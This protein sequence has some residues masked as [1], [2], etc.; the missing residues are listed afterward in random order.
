MNIC[1]ELGAP[2]EQPGR[3]GYTDHWLL[4]LEGT[5][6]REA[7]EA[8]IALGTAVDYLAV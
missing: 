3:L 6:V 8:P 4:E 1:W 7:L 2:Q 5:A